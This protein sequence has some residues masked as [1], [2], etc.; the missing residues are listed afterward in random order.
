MFYV[1]S[2][3]FRGLIAEFKTY[4]EAEEFCGK[5]GIPCEDIYEWD[6]DDEL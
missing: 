6:E 1:E 5:A 3:F 2:P 4:E